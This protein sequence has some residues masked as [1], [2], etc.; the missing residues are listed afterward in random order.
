M[1]ILVNLYKVRRIFNSSSD[2]LLTSSTEAL[3]SCVSAACA[4]VKLD[5][6]LMVLI[7]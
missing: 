6:P 3:T 5:M 2:I 4:S 7:I 1:P